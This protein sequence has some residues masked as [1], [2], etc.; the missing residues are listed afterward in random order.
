MIVGP[1]FLSVLSLALI[2]L[3]LSAGSAQASTLATKRHAFCRVD[4][5]CWSDHYCGSD[6]KCAPK[7]HDGEECSLDK[8]CW[9]GK[10]DSETGA[11]IA[12][13]AERATPV[14]AEP[15]VKRSVVE[16]KPI[17]KRATKQQKKDAAEAKRELAAARALLAKA[18]RRAKAASVKSENLHKAAAAA[19]KK[20]S[21][22]RAAYRKASGARKAYLKMRLQSAIKASKAA[23]H[24]AS[25]AGAAAAKA[26]K[27]EAKVVATT[28]AAKRKSDTATAV[29]EGKPAPVYA[30]R[31]NG[32][33][34]LSGSECSSGFCNK[35]A[36]A[37]TPHCHAIVAVITLDP[38]DIVVSTTVMLV[39]AFKFST[40]VALRC[41]SLRLRQD[42]VLRRE[43]MSSR[44]RQ[45]SFTFRLFN[46]RHRATTE[47]QGKTA[48][49]MGHLEQLPLSNGKAQYGRSNT[50]GAIGRR[51]RLVLCLILA[52]AALC[53]LSSTV[54]IDV[55]ETAAPLLDKV[56]PS[57]S[58]R[59]KLWSDAMAQVRPALGRVRPSSALP[60][61]SNAPA[62][63]L[64]STPKGEVAHAA[65]VAAAAAPVHKTKPI[66]KPSLRI[67]ILENWACHDEVTASFMQALSRTKHNVISYLRDIRFEAEKIYE[68]FD[69]KYPPFIIDNAVF[70]KGLPP[71]AVISVSCKNDVGRFSHQ[72]NLDAMA[73]QATTM[74]YCVIHDCNEW[75]AHVPDWEGDEGID[76]RPIMRH[77]AEQDRVRFL[78]LSPHV[79]ECVKSK[80]LPYLGISNDSVVAKTDRQ[81]ALDLSHD[82]IWLAVQGKLDPGRRSYTDLF[83]ALISR[84]QGEKTAFMS[85]VKLLVLGASP[86]DKKGKALSWPAPLRGKITVGE[87]LPYPQFYDAL[88]HVGALLPSFSK[89]SYLESKASSTVAASLI[90]GAPM[91]ADQAI[92][93]KYSYLTRECVWF[94]E[95][96]ETEL[97]AA[98]RGMSE[99]SSAQAITQK[100]ACLKRLKDRIVAQNAVD[101]ERW[102]EE[103]LRESGLL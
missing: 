27:K 44:S 10:C 98:L 65:A 56:V 2:A 13:I 75:D 45:P 47:Q 20:E 92:L 6:S 23:H 46:L 86:P 100:K 50:L 57:A 93:D 5:A 15:V 68:S 37:F 58:Q 76:G 94:R 102:I 29:A 64:V 59:E 63:P 24:R 19:E 8:A 14:A 48:R 60:A 40:I 3:F 42:R 103:D 78:T 32:S 33:P 61:P 43:I 97:E 51:G 1:K 82:S 70:G 77:W 38:L 16:N 96:A 88:R 91:V 85:K 31:G 67:A 69:W 21:K 99:V 84:I 41:Q 101:L 81:K 52:F 34:C 35:S 4:A 95:E 12:P 74:L 22:L 30:L 90:S 11:C 25:L 72:L 54:T 87:S 39:N 53:W 66:D 73:D 36:N 49:T 89:R 18:H 7:L 17:Q 79:T 71:Q 28:W 80:T 9:S 62:R 55:D 83:S 26:T